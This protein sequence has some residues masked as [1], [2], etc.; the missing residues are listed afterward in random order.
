[1]KQCKADAVRGGAKQQRGSTEAVAR[2][3]Q[4]SEMRTAA[5]ERESRPLRALP[6][7]RQ[8]ADDRLSRAHYSMGDWPVEKC[9]AG[10]GGALQVCLPPACSLCG[11]GSSGTELRA[12]PICTGSWGKANRVSTR[13]RA[14]RPILALAQRYERD[15]DRR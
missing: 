14:H 6:W 12:A 8:A 9:D 11:F 4:R 3:F 13:L 7:N 10:L 5:E 15:A 2:S 1:M